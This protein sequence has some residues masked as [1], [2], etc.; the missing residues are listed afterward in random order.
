MSTYSAAPSREK[1]MRISNSIDR[2]ELLR[3]MAR[4][5]RRQIDIVPDT[6]GNAYFCLN[7][8]QPIPDELCARC[9]TTHYSAPILT[10]EQLASVRWI[11]SHVNIDT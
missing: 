6:E 8:W 9:R 2:R 4:T 1:Y 10:L 5:L 3:D 11:L 7:C